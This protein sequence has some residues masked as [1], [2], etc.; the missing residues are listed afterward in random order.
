MGSG[1]ATFLHKLKGMVKMNWMYT[2]NLKD[3]LNSNDGDDYIVELI[4]YLV[5][6]LKEISKRTRTDE[7]NYALKELV[8]DCGNDID[9]VVIELESIKES[10]EN[11]EDA[12]EVSLDTWTDGFNNSLND[13]YDIGDT[14]LGDGKK[15]LFVI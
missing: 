10:I 6:Q 15:F 13:L 12:E 2:I 3:K 9:E 5:P 7:M 14:Y 11:G 4:N 1:N 8:V